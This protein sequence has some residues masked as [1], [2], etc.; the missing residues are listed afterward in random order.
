M[1][2]DS[3]GRL[4]YDAGFREKITV[5]T[6][7]Y[8]YAGRKWEHERNLEGYERLQSIIHGS[9]TVAVTSLG[10][11]Q[12]RLSEIEQFWDKRSN[13]LK[14]PLIL[15]FQG[16]Q[17][18]FVNQRSLYF[19]DYN[20]FGSETT[21]FEGLDEY[22]TT[23]SYSKGDPIIY[24][25]PAHKT[26]RPSPL[27][28]FANEYREYA[29]Y[30]SKTAFGNSRSGMHHPIAA[31]NLTCIFADVVVVMHA[32]DKT[33]SPDYVDIEPVDSELQNDGIK[34]GKIFIINLH[35]GDDGRFIDADNYE[36]YDKMYMF[37]N[38]GLRR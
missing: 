31:I 7:W 3:V 37:M 8:D 14:L 15:Y 17:N 25:V 38:G 16:N 19:G 18:V 22:C 27:K 28:D 32:G 21:S 33:V 20:I 26:R 2:K 12:R 35:F 23:N 9:K 24:A 1:R 13:D 10:D 5:V 6:L 36:G 34:F 11:R 4:L 29:N 30:I